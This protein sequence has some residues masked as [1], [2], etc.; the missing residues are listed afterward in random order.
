MPNSFPPFHADFFVFFILLGIAQGLLLSYF[1]LR[2]KETANR[3]FG[4]ALLVMSILVFDVWLGDRK[5][6]RLN[7]SHS[8][9]SRMPSSA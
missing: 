9:L 1:F 5:S 7:Y 8:T 2:Q 4:L 6:T 3:Y